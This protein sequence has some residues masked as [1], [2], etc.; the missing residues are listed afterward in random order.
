M[1]GETP[2]CVIILPRGGRRW[3]HLM[4]FVFVFV[5]FFGVFKAAPVAYGGSQVMG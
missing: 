3:T 5:F 4:G 1:E 2:A